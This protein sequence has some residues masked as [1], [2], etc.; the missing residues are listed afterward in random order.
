M[1]ELYTFV[2]RGILTDASLDK[3]G[4]RERSIFGTEEAER[5][6]AALYFDL[7][8]VE[9]LAQAEQMAVIYTAIHAFENSVRQFVSMAMAEIY[10][11]NWWEE[12][13]ERIR[14]KA[15]KR[16]LDDSKF[17][18]HGSRGGSDI[19]Y[20]DFGDLSEIIDNK[21]DVFRDVL[22][23]R[24][25]AKSTLRILNRSRNSIMHGN[26]LATQD[27]ER[28]GMNIKDWLHQAG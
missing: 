11:A 6:K 28:I 10:D 17:R 9:R 13:P 5:T 24:A 7:L 18:W 2:Y 8:D 27:I 1:D 14:E 21:W 23:D 12:V 16:M 19:E 26:I 3:V 25:W 4:R 22:E 15:A 20:S